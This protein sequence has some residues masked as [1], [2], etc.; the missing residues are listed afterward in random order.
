MT[1][2][3]GILRGALYARFADL[4]G[5]IVASVAFLGIWILSSTIGPAGFAIGAVAGLLTA[6]LL[7]RLRMFWPLMALAVAIYVSGAKPDNSKSMPPDAASTP[8][9]QAQ[10]DADFATPGPLQGP[11]ALDASAPAANEQ[12]GS[13][14]SPSAIETIL[15]GKPT[16]S[17]A[18]TDDAGPPWLRDNAPKVSNDDAGPPWLKDDGPKTEDSNAPKQ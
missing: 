13:N 9:T 11:R 12:P 6:I 16:S 2:R 7:W 8:I 15:A 3:D 1:N 10:L 5:Y 4:I 18:P 14:A 17:K